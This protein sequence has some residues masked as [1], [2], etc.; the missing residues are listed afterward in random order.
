MLGD[1]KNENGIDL[2]SIDPRQCALLVI[3]ALGDPQGGPLEG[4]LLEPTLNCGRLAAAARAAGIPVVL[5]NDAH[6]KGLD[7]ELLLWGEHGLAGPPE[8]QA[9]PQVGQQPSDHVVEKRRYSA[10][11]Q[12]GLRLLLDELGA[13]ILICCGF[14]TN[15]CVRHTVADAYF[16]NLD[17][18]VV[19]DATATF[20]VGDQASGLD[21][22]KVCYGSALV[23]TDEAIAVMEGQLR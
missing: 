3:D 12:T 6:I 17:T 21:Y 11:F 14:D 2:A 20:L 10:F 19:A 4:L 22:M 23:G 9:S 7:R 8:A 5:A 15:I 18:I 16:N 1:D 13:R